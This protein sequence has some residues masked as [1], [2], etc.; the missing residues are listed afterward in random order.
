M[1]DDEQIPDPLAAF[2]QALRASADVAKVVRSYHQALV[3]EGFDPPE[4]LQ[5]TLAYQ[6]M[7]IGAALS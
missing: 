7:L 3:G 2:D 6:S 1:S 5:L 4:A